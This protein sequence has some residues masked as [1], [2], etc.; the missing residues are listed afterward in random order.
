MS[1]TVDIRLETDGRWQA[2]VLEI[3]GIVAHG[4]TAD[5]AAHNVQALS[6]R[7]LADRVEKGEDIGP[8]NIFSEASSATASPSFDAASQYVLT[9][10]KDL[11]RRLA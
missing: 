3:P 4:S 11:Y 2:T 5:E 7:S 9:K 6:L 1:L 8:L 10:N